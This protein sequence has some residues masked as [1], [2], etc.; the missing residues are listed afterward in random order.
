MI[1][2]SPLLLNFIEENKTP[3]LTNSPAYALTPYSKRISKNNEMYKM[4]LVNGMVS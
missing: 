4:A 1:T 2:N 3:P